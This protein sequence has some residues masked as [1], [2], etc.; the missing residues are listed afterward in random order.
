MAAAVGASTYPVTGKPLVEL[1][2][3][4]VGKAPCVQ[5]LADRQIQL[6]VYNGTSRVWGSH[7]CAVQPGVDKRTLAVGQPYRYGIV[8]GGLTSQPGCD[9]ATRQHIGAGTYTLYASL[10]GKTGSS[11]QFTVG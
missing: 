8:W 4:N 9:Q 11:T 1:Q 7:D 5:D 6:L 2:V 10:S 3:R